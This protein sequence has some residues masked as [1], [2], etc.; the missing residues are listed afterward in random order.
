MN[1]QWYTAL[2]C[3]RHLNTP[4]QT[5]QCSAASLVHVLFDFWR[6]IVV[7]GSTVMLTILRQ[8]RRG[9]CLAECLLKTFLHRFSSK[10]QGEEGLGWIKLGSGGWG[11]LWCCLGESRKRAGMWL[12]CSARLLLHQN[13]RFWL[14][15][16]PCRDS[17]S[18]RWLSGTFAFLQLSV[19]DNNLWEISLKSLFESETLFW[20]AP[21]SV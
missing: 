18:R 15:F 16:N 13:E 10:L 1:T 19:S 2:V 11:C 9:L 17:E 20:N 8:S 12:N 7:G 3:T 14:L 4:A 6:F 21:L 5:V